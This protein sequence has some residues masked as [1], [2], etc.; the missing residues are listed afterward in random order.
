MDENI[1][2]KRRLAQ[3]ANVWLC[4]DELEAE[5]GKRLAIT[6]EKACFVLSIERLG[7]VVDLETGDVLWD[8]AVE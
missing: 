6:R 7:G 1:K 8:V 3:L 5:A 4:L 2:E